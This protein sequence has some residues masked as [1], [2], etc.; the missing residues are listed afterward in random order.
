MKK[1]PLAEK[2]ILTP[3]E[4]IQY[5]CLSRRKFYRWMEKPTDCQ[6]KCNA[7]EK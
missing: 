6:A 4:A 3:E 5:F 2:D 1:V 7:F